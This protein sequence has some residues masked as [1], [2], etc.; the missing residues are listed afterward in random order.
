MYAGIL[1]ENLAQGLLKIG[2]YV[3]RLITPIA[4]KAFWWKPWLIAGVVV[5]A[6]AI[7]T[8]AILAIH[9]SE[10]NSI[11]KIYQILQDTMVRMNVKKPQRQ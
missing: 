5:A 10:V 1:L 2:I 7:I 9:Y 3:T 11:K 8:T 4:A 6:V